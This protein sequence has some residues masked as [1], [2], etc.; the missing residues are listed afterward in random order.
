MPEFTDPRIISLAFGEIPADEAD[1]LRAELCKDP[2]I[3]KELAEFE[4]LQA[5]LHLLNDIPPSQL[6]SERL[7][8]TILRQGLKPQSRPWWIGWGWAPVAAFVAVFALT[9]YKMSLREPEIRVSLDAISNP[10]AMVAPQGLGTGPTSTLVTKSAPVASKNLAKA[11][12]TSQP[13]KKRRHRKVEEESDPNLYAMVTSSVPGGLPI[14]NDAALPMIKQAP[15]SSDQGQVVLINSEV[16]EHSG[17][18]KAQEVEG[19]P[20]VP[21]GG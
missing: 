2:A 18:Q 20:S 3:A 7:R 19:T 4:S 8:D 9:N 16:D 12:L 1:R 10:V 15:V 21:V 14:S 13:A 11:T 5:S 6:S 17:A